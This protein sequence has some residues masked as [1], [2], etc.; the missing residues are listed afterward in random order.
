MYY[1]Y[2]LRCADSTLYCG[3]TN[4]LDRR[5]KEHNESKLKAAKYTKS[6]RPTVLVYS[7]T[8]PTL[9]LA[10]K[11]EYEVKHW[12]KKQKEVLVASL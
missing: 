9:Q 11:R 10:M 1:F 5:L 4:D 6:R 2:I 7:E 8:Y 3:Q 12:A